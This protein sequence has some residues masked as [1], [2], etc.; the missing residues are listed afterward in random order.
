LERKDINKTGY[1]SNKLE[2]EIALK[3]NLH[4]LIGI[5]F[6]LDNERIQSND[7]TNKE[8]TAGEKERLNELLN[9]TLAYKEELSVKDE[10]EKEVRIGKN[11]NVY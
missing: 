7:E 4:Q 5:E 9:P 8:E 6:E 10:K 11:P 2:E 3:N 1:Y